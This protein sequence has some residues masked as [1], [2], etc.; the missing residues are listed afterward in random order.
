MLPLPAVAGLLFLTAGWLTFAAAA[1]P[2]PMD[3]VRQFY[4]VLLDTMQHGPAL[5]AKGRYQKLEPVVLR[6]FDVPF[7]TRLSIG[8]SWS[9]L[10][11]EQKRR[12]ATAYGRYITAVYATR[13]DEYS[14]EKF[15]VLGE[16]QIKHGTLVKSQIIKSNGEPVSINYV[17][18]DNNVAWQIRDA[19]LSGSI[20]E[21]ATRRSEFSAILRTNGIDALIATLNKKADDLQI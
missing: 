4:G 17:L 19:Y 13:F 14:G 10:T 21:L 15:Q 1:T 9:K 12:A 16:Q 18:H 11:P 5:G 8:P 3:A 2:G 7:M 6:T 20:S